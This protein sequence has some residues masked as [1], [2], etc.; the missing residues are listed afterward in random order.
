MDLSN[1]GLIE[2]P[3]NLHKEINESF[4]CIQ[5]Q[6]TTLE[7]CPQIVNGGFY[8]HNNKLTT[9]EGGPKEVYSTF[10]CLSNLNLSLKEILKFMSKCYIGGDIL[11]DYGNLTEYKNMKLSDREITKII[12]RIK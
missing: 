8:C 6:L 3:N 2:I 1:K 9:L 4:W 7:G 11:T 5:N 10:C 12:L